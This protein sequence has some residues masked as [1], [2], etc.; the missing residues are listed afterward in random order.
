MLVHSRNF[1]K[2]STHEDPYHFHKCLGVLCLIHFVFRVYNLF[3]YGDMLFVDPFWDWVWFGLHFLLSVSSLQFVIPSNRVQSMIV[4][5]PEFRAHSILFAMRSLACIVCSYVLPDILLLQTACG[6]LVLLTMVAADMATTHY[7]TDKTTMRGMSWPNV[8]PMNHPYYQ[9]AH[10]FFYSFSQIGATLSMF[11]GNYPDHP[12]LVLLPIQIAPFLSTLVKKGILRDLH[13][14][15]VY[16][17]SLLLPYC[18]GWVANRPSLV[19]MDWMV[20]IAFLRFYLRVNKYVLW[21]MVFLMAMA[22]TIHEEKKYLF[23]P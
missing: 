11:M 9:D 18:Y 4:I 16:T 7:K 1:Y 10:N 21:G 5:W 20:G 14:H 2:L 15:L 6:I 17:L 13:W 23:Y 12:F 8:F 3:V 19:R 22:R